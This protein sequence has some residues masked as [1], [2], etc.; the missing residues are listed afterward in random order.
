MD[1]NVC[2]DSAVCRLYAFQ[3][4]DSAFQLP[5]SSAPNPCL[6]V[7]RIMCLQFPNLLLFSFSNPHF[8]FPNFHFPVSESRFSDL[9]FAFSVSEE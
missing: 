8:W 7:S 6:L 2:S 9:E 5:E 1:D 4:P 3:F